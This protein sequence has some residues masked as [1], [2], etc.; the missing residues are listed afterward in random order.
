MKIA[1]VGAG[2]AGVTTAYELAADGHQVTVFERHGAVAEEASFAP[3]GLLATELVAPWTAPLRLD[4]RLSLAEL[5]WLWRWRRA[6]QP[7]VWAA[8]R[9]RLQRLAV[10]SRARLH[11]LTAELR[12]DYERSD[13]ALLLLRSDK[14]LERLRESGLDLREISADQARKLEPALNPDTTLA[15]AVHLP[16]AEAGNCRQLAL[17]LRQE[18]QRLGARF[19]FNAT[20][21]RIEA[22]QP[23]ALRLANEEA[24]RA[25]DAV[26]LCAGLASA[27]LLRPLGLKLPL[28][29]VQGSSVSLPLREAL[30]APRSAVHDERH[31]VT[32]TRLGQ[33]VRVA[34]GAQLGGGD[35][36]RALRQLYQVLQDWF[37]GAGR[38]SAGVQVWHGARPM[39]ADG[40]PLLG[41]SGRPGLWLNLG[42]GAHG[43]A[44]ACGSAR[45][46]ADLIA[47][48]PPALDL[49]G[50]GVERLR[51]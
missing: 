46:L 40:P 1:I 13:G 16:Q 9:A 42:H 38:L 41:A 20:V 43:W 4:M 51:R 17:L 35:R 27:R 28:A 3:T 2:I 50:L 45:A 32:I 14:E 31:Q 33:R 15:G 18:A 23:H 39:L 25:F 19:E 47:G 29:A 49:E 11:Q 24:A 37:P 34:G 22:K 26:V 30:N 5:A 36:E 48:R 12:L 7:Q 21:T 8:N 44:L 10:Y 6:R